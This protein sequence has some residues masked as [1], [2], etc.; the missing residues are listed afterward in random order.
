MSGRQQRDLA[1]KS[2]RNQSKDE[3]AKKQGF[4][5][6]REAALR[7]ETSKTTMTKK[8]F[9][10][11][12][13]LINFYHAQRYFIQTTNNLVLYKTT[14]QVKILFAQLKGRIAELMIFLKN[15]EENGKNILGSDNMITAWIGSLTFL[16]V[17]VLYVLLALG[18]PY[19]DLAMGGKYKVLPKQMRVACAISV[20]IQLIA[21]LF[22]LQAGNVI[23]IGEIETLQKGDVISSHFIY[24]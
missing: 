17:A 20:V 19:G 8:I 24:S 15:E 22:I 1:P 3:T 5:T 2:N 12:L 21:I 23:S 4:T 13:K 10:E 18:L 7:L 6:V 11:E 14:F 9:N 16:A